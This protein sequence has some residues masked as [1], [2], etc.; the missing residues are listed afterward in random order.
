MCAQ[1]VQ[2]DKRHFQF[3]VILDIVLVVAA[4]LAVYSY[5]KTTGRYDRQFKDVSSQ[6]ET[7]KAENKQFTSNQIL[8]L[9]SLRVRDSVIASVNYR[10][11][12]T[13]AQI[14]TVNT[15]LQHQ[16]DSVKS[17]AY[18]EMVRRLDSIVTT[19]LKL[20]VGRPN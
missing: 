6:Y 8:V 17:V 16:L 2:I 18:E 11:A 1:V 13:S 9:D 14:R 10:K 4:G 12:L 19:R 7:L 15:G 5:M 20:S 3:R